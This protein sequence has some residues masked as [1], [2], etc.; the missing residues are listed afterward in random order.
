MSCH[1][2]YIGEGRWHCVHF[3]RHTTFSSEHCFVISTKLA[4]TAWYA[5]LYFEQHFIDVP[6]LAHQEMLL[7]TWL[8]ETWGRLIETYWRSVCSPWPDLPCSGT[9]HSWNK[10]SF[11]Y[12]CWFARSNQLGLRRTFH[13]NRH[14][15]AGLAVRL[16]PFVAYFHPYTFP[17]GWQS[18]PVKGHESRSLCIVITTHHIRSAL[19]SNTSPLPPPKL[20][21]WTLPGRRKHSCTGPDLTLFC[22]S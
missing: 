10:N 21:D 8:Q 6:V 16:V 12:R 7:E 20:L 14:K 1:M 11:N 13:Y 9:W 15:D 19:T 2:G 22:G 18:S 4:K 3:R 5:C 17:P